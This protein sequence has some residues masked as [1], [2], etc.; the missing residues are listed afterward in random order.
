MQEDADN[1]ERDGGTEDAEKAQSFVKP[2]FIAV[3]VG[4]AVLVVVM[5]LMMLAVTQAP[6]SFVDN[7]RSQ[8]IAAPSADYAG[9]VVVE[10][11]VSK[12]LANTDGIRELEIGGFVRNVGNSPVRAADIRCY[13]R[14]GSGGELVLELPLIVDT[15]L[16]EV[17]VGGLMPMSR[18]RFG[19]RV[20]RFPENVSSEVAR[21][22]VINVSLRN[23]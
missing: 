18:R 15:R 12:L 2:P 22:E 16:T 19:V 7:S 1:P 5:F 6:P 21:I 9:H 10:E 8:P 17:G 11:P 20:G 23:L 14:K 3:A 13:F 4:A